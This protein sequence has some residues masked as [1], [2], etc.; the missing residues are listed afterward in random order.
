MRPVDWLPPLAWMAVILWLAGDSGS[1]ER[2]G[3]LLIPIFRFLAPGASPLQLEALHGIARK[4]GHVTEY[5]VL[6][7]LWLRAFTAGGG[8]ARRSAAWRAWGI[9]VGWAVVDE[10]LQWA[11]A[12]RTGSALD[13]LLD[14]VGA[15]AVALPGA[16]GWRPAADVLARLSLWIA[17]V[18]GLALVAVNLLTGIESGVLWLTVPAAVL[19]LALFRRARPSGAGR[20]CRAGRPRRG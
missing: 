15:L 19:A 14:A 18:G 6:A 4:L 17:A 1:A 7:A 12:S 13:V 8:L 10:A 9:A 20:A 2:T 16:W 5:A 11:S 3:R